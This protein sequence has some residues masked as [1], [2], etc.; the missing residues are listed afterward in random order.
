M[1]RLGGE[2]DAEL[3]KREKADD[4]D[5][6]NDKQ[7]EH[8][9]KLGWIDQDDVFTP[10]TRFLRPP[11]SMWNIRKVDTRKYL[12]NPENKDAL[13]FAEKVE[14]LGE[15]MHRRNKELRRRTFEQ[16]KSMNAT[17]PTRESGPEILVWMPARWR[18]NAQ[19]SLISG[20]RA[21]WINEKCPVKCRATNTAGNKAHILFHIAK[22]ASLEHGWPVPQVEDWQARA[23]VSVE[24]HTMLFAPPGVPDIMIHYD[25][26]SDMPRRY[27]MCVALRGDNT[28]FLP[29]P[30]S[31]HNMK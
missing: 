4:V 28:P 12:Q 16:L 13:E 29:A 14:K 31:I 22:L 24:P 27:G 18:G 20:L 2:I 26:Y 6:F 19:K 9:K 10:Y 1:T 30:S 15:E 21:K 8:F 5:L 17:Y 7:Q 11:V 25:Y 3:K 23:V